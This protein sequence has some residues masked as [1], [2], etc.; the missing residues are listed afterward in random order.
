MD[1]IYDLK[2]RFYQKKLNK[3]RLDLRDLKYDVF[4]WKILKTF[5]SKKAIK[6]TKIYDQMITEKEK[7]IDNLFEKFIRSI[8]GIKP[9]KKKN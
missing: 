5:K 8:Y 9:L 7:E 1:I 6:M 3:A 2:K 4:F